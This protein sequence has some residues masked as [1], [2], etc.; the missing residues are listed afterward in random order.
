MKRTGFTIIELLIVLAGTAIVVALTVPIGIRF[1]YSQTLDEATSNI[2]STLRRSESQAKFSK[3]DSAFG[4]KFLSGS[5][6]LFQGSSYASRT[7]SEDESFAL[8]GGITTSGIT[9][10]VFAKVTGIPSVTGTLTVSFLGD[11]KTVTINAQGEI[12][13]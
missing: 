6:V 4:V 7:Q 2:M 12:E 1:F 11:S 3:N 10:I 5:Y 13:R 9:E 8:L